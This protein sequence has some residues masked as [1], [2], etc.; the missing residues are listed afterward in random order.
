MPA[1]RPPTIQPAAAA[2]WQNIASLPS[3][4]LHEEVARRMEERLDLIRLVPKTWAH[5]EPVHG[6]M[7][8]H[9][10]LMRRYPESE[11]FMA[12]SHEKHAQEAI[13]NIA[14]PWWQPARWKASRT[15]FEAPPEGA[16]QMV[17]GNMA[18]HMVADPQALIA[19]WHKA[20]ATDGFLMFSCFGPDTLRELRAFYPQMGWPAPSHEFTDMHD[21]GDMLVASGFA[22]PVMDVEHITLTYETPERLLAEL[23]SLGRNLH[24]ARFP[25]LRGRRWLAHLHNALREHLADPQNGGRLKLTF[26]VIYGHAIK[27]QK[28][29]AVR[30]E[31]NISLDEMR[32]A[33]RSGKTDKP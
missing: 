14:K 16:V 26:E 18:L 30:P 9:E 25:A 32:R 33:L 8:A 23:R 12:L 28:R 2:R 4:W 31:L 5:W 15:R 1:E 20:L 22:E 27:P 24:P 21:W 17:W 7:A 3:P 19:Q 13:K 29:L 10:L 11:C 6:G